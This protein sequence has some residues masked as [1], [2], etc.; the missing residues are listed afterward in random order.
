MTLEIELDAAIKLTDK[1]DE[2]NK[3]LAKHERETPRTLKLPVGLNA[4]ASYVVLPGP[5][6][7]RQWQIRR[8][9]LDSPASLS[10]SL[11][12][13]G[14]GS[15]TDPAGG[16]LIAQTTVN[17]PA[18]VYTVTVTVG[19]GATAGTVAGNFT[20]N[21][22]GAAYIRGLGPALLANGSAT[23]TFYNVSSDGAHRFSI[24]AGSADASGVYTA[25]ILATPAG[26][27]GVLMYSDE[28]LSQA[29]LLWE[30]SSSPVSETF[31]RDEMTLVHPEV[32]VIDTVASGTALAGS[33]QVIDMPAGEYVR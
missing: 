16:G 5:N 6:Q 23:Y 7:G 27:G 31:G 13:A 30:F 15:A 17:A 3:R 8:V 22:E 25:S 21:A 20:L 4:T 18:G 26:L 33:V 9:Q 32:L 12:I 29:S 19:Y 2:L 24:T 28:S 1:I 10:G 14:S 11:P